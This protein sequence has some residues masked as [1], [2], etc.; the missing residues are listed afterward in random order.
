MKQIVT[1][2]VTLVLFSPKALTQTQVSVFNRDASLFYQTITVELDGSDKYSIPLPDIAIDEQS[3]MLFGDLPIMEYSLVRSDFTSGFYS[4]L[5]DKKVK[6][7]NG[8]QELSGS[9]KEISGQ[10][11]ILLLETG[12]T[13]FISDLSTFIIQSEGLKLPPKQGSH[14]EVVF[15]LTKTKKKSVN[16]EMIYRSRVFAWSVRYLLVVDK[17]YNLISLNGSA[18]I[19]NNSLAP[20]SGL[21]MT[22]LFGNMEKNYQSR[23]Y[24]AKAQFAMDEV[25]VTA[26]EAADMYHYTIPYLLDFSAGE[27][28]MVNLI[29]TDKLKSEQSYVYYSYGNSTKGKP[30]VTLKLDLKSDKAVKSALPGG[31]VQV[32]I[33]EKN[34]MSALTQTMVQHTPRDG[35]MILSLGEAMD[36]SIDE[37]AIESNRITNKITEDKFRIEITN[38]KR[39][40][41]TLNVNRYLKEYQKITFSTEKMKEKSVNLTELYIEIGVGETKVVDYTIRSEYR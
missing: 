15:S 20:F 29:S 25:V 19:Q 33:K 35:K 8:N 5:I 1:L 14:R 41:V 13:I 2:L 39:E 10:S 37:Y 12:N 31:N 16:L 26:N 36:I 38:S 3:L 11:A 30:T 28:K 4:T 9:V 21:D 34:K 22:L 32:M 23:G 27:Q 24:E 18:T 7:S 17:E 40:S 6:L